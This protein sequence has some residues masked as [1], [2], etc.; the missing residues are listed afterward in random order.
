MGAAKT[1]W[2][3]TVVDSRCFDNCVT[4]NF[5]TAMWKINNFVVKVFVLEFDKSLTLGEK[6]VS[7]TFEINNIVVVNKL[8]PKTSNVKWFV[9]QSVDLQQ[10]GLFIT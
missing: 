5:T 3:Y 9:I 7:A 8:Q 4:D 2:K 1:A 10:Y 6:T